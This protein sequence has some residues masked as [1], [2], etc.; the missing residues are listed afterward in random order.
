LEPLD[1]VLS[2]ARQR[3]IS[4]FL[5][6]QTFLDARLIPGALLP[7]LTCGDAIFGLVA[8]AIGAKGFALGLFLGK[9]TRSILLAILPLTT[10]R[11]LPTM[12]VQ[13]YPVLLAIGL[14]QVIS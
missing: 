1:V 12:L 3:P 5:K 11:M 7:W 13:L 10:R 9:W 8:I 14:D 4:P 2:R 6:V